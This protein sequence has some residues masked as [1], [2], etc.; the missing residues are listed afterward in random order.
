[1]YAVV[2]GTL[3]SIDFSTT[4]I[5][6]SF[7]LVEMNTAHDSFFILFDD[8]RRSDFGLIGVLSGRPERTPLTE[9]VPALVKFDLYRPQ[10]SSVFFRQRLLGLEP[11]LLRHQVLDVSKH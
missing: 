11:M 4:D 2:T 3:I 5:L 1:L 6:S 7:R 10:A 8:V 9:K